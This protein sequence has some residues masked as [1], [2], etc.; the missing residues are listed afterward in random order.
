MEEGIANKVSIG[1]FHS[2][3][4]HECLLWMIWK[5]RWSPTV[6]CEDCHSYNGRDCTCYFKL[7]PSWARQEE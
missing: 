6:H 1:C 5:L 4:C 3:L 2:S 7:P